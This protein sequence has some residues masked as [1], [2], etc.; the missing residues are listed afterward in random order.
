VAAEGLAAGGRVGDRA[1]LFEDRRREDNLFGAAP[2]AVGDHP[3]SIRW[4]D[5]AVR[6]E[7]LVNLFENRAAEPV[8]LLLASP[9]PCLAHHGHLHAFAAWWMVALGRWALGAGATLH[10]G[11]DDVTNTCRGVL[12]AHRVAESVSSAMKDASVDAIDRL[13]HWATVIAIA[14]AKATPDFVYGLADR[15][16]GRWGR[17]YVLVAADDLR[18]ASRRVRKIVG[19]GVTLKKSGEA[20]TRDAVETAI[21]AGER[22]GVPVVP[23]VIEDAVADCQTAVRRLALG[24][25]P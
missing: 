15:L 2:Y 4:R 17:V 14:S 10:V 25:P 5:F 13:P 18:V 9:T 3:G 1:A 24:G 7:L 16:C 12:Q 11:N 22:C 8:V 6:D 21:T 19:G 20:A 23:V